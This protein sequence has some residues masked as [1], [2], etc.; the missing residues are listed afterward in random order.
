V[1]P[2]DGAVAARE[3]AGCSAS[4]R[5]RGRRR[6]TRYRSRERYRA[7]LELAEVAQT[8]HSALVRRASIADLLQATRL[9]LTQINK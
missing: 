2:I 6:T 1:S 4:L 3:I 9:F 7:F 8:A 5:R